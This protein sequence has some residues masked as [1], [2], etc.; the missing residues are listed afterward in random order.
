M[1]LVHHLDYFLF[2][3]AGDANEGHSLFNSLQQR[4][5]SDIHR[6]LGS[7]CLFRSWFLPLRS[8]SSS[9]VTLLTWELTG[10]LWTLA[11]C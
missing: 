5:L 8:L 7:P 11:D 2:A 3:V 10:S 1:K 6:S 4:V 9:W